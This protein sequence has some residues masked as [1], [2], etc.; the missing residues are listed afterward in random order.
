[1]T[2][3]EK[4]LAED[5][6]TRESDAHAHGE[7]IRVSAYNGFPNL[8]EFLNK[9]KQVAEEKYSREVI[10]HA[11]AMKT[12]DDLKRRIHDLQLSD[13]NNRTAAETA[14]AKLSTSEGSWSQQR[15]NL[16]RSIADLTARCKAL[17]EQNNVLHQHLENVSSQATRIR[18]AA[19]ADVATTS[20]PPGEGSGDT[21]ANDNNGTEAKWS[22][23]RAVIN[24]LRKEKEIV[25]MQLEL[26]KQENARLKTQIGHLTR[27]LEDTRTTLSDVSSTPPPPTQRCDKNPI[28]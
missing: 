11:E 23:L 26:G 27:D 2:A 5:R 12:I 17:T 19:A 13:R 1:M 21:T 14:Q 16:D 8:H 10:A 20:T 3:S 24:Y 25:D 4:N 6:L 18:Q 28:Y 9:T 15:Q 7:R 22:E